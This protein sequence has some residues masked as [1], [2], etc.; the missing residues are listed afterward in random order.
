M[1]LETLCEFHLQLNVFSIQDHNFILYSKDSLGEK[2]TT[3]AGR[4][5]IE[6]QHSVSSQQLSHTNF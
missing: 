6:H 1:Y 5:L 2:N 3:V 4:V